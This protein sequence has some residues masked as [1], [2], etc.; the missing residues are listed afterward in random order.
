MNKKLWIKVA[1][2]TLIAALIAPA[3]MAGH[4]QRAVRQTPRLDVLAYELREASRQVRIEAVFRAR[5]RH[6]HRGHGRIDGRVIGTLTG[7]ERETNRFLQAVDSRNPHRV[8][9]EYARLV[10]AFD[11]A[12]WEMETVRSKQVRREF[13]DVEFL[14]QR[15]V[16]R[17]EMTA[18]H[19]P[20]RPGYERP[21]GGVHGSVVLGDVIGNARVG[22]RVDW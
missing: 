13:R 14:M 1:L 17:M 18:R 12:Y 11:R 5:N 8:E 10:R 2:I 9:R 6:A 22:I 7:L 19:R 15:V 4:K 21:R 20:G 16:R 3:A